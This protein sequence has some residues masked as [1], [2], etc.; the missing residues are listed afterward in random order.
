MEKGAEVYYMSVNPVE[1][2]PYISNEDIANFNNIL[3]NNLPSETG[4]IETNSYLLEV[5]IPHR[6]AYTLMRKRI[7]KYL[8]IQWKCCLDSDDNKNVWRK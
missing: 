7:R 6:T 4:W 2:H 8:I 3:Y 5:D 1:N